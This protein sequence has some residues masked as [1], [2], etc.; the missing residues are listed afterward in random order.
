MLN[1]FLLENV[2]YVIICINKKS[3]NFNSTSL[4]PI[5]F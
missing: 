1:P 4:N 3:E 2:K 5:F